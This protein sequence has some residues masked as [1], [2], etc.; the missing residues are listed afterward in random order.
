MPVVE[1]HAGKPLAEN[2]T[3]T[4]LDY[5][6]KS[7]SKKSDQRVRAASKVPVQK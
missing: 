3:K 5:G 1:G 7:S 4:I 2:Y 6:R